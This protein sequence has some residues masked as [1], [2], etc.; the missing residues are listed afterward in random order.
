KMI[1]SGGHASQGELTRFR[2]EAEA[3]ARMRH[4]NIVQIYEVGEHNGLPFFSLEYCSGGGLDR[5]LLGPLT[6]RPA[7]ELVKTLAEAV[8]AA[9]QAGI[10]H[11]DLKPANVLLLSDGTPK[12]T[13][14]GLAKKLEGGDGLTQSGAVMGTP[15]Y[16]APEQASGQSSHVTT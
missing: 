5:K 16:M 8:H 6:P 2:G 7:V 12:I 9:H 15:S 3:L 10:I 11:R 13:D 4:P 14:F 1:L